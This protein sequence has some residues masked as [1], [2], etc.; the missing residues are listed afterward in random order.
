MPS[1]TPSGKSRPVC[2]TDA[3]YYLKILLG[4]AV[5][6]IVWYMPPIAPLTQAGMRVLDLFCAIL[7][8]CALDEMIW[9]GVLA[10]VCMNF[11]I[12]DIYPDSVTTG[13]YRAIELSWGFWMIPFIAASLILAFALKECGFMDRVAGWI[14]SRK[15]ARKSPWTFTIAWMF[16]SLFLGLFFDP[17]ATIVFCVGFSEELFLRIGYKKGDS[18]PRAV[19]IGMAFASMIAYGMTPISHPLPIMALGVYETLTGRSMSFVQ[20]MAAG[21]PVGLLCF[22]VLVLIVKYVMRPDMTLLENA[23][24]EDILGQRR[25]PMKPREKATV[26]V[27]VAVMACWLLFGLLETLAPQAAL[28]LFCSELT[29]VTPALVGTALLALIRI[30]GKALMPI[31]HGLKYGVTWNVLLLLAGLLMTGNALSQ[32]STGFPALLEMILEPLLHAG[33]P[34]AAVLALVVCMGVVCTNFLNNIPVV[35]LL[36]AACIPMAQPL[37]V[38]AAAITFLI[39][40]AGQMAFAA[41]SSFAAIAY[42]YGVDWAAPR[43][44]FRNGCVLM[45]GCILVISTVGYW[46]SCLVF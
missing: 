13:L 10:V 25:P 29:T 21:I 15:I 12:G 33:L 14:L 27:C 6:A 31:D 45:L 37:G 34:A 9:P 35:M 30:D 19:T 41:P 40:F 44:I 32:E 17:L 39:T 11:L 8:F 22:L 36:L 18:Y 38:S 7:Y 1:L 24:F 16:A 28:T 42:L 3:V 4:L 20:Y 46:V 23:R 2:R 26:L 5:A 43:E